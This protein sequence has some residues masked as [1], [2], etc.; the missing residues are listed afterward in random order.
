[1]GGSK[2]VAKFLLNVVDPCDPWTA[3]TLAAA[4]DSEGL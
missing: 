4:K 2:L 1:M 3:G